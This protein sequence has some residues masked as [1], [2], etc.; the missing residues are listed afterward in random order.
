VSGEYA[1][2]SWYSVTELNLDDVADD[3]LFS[4]HVQLL[5]VTYHDRELE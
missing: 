5:T 3:Q 4:V 1:D 2:I